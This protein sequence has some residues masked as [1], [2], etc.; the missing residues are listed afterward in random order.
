MFRW[1]GDSEVCYAFLSDVDADEPPSAEY[2]SF[3]MSRWFTRGWTLQELIAPGVVYFYGAG[4]KQIGSRETLLDIVVEITKI[5]AMYF[6]T[7]DLSKFPA[8]QKMSWAAGRDTTRVE[9]MAYCLLGIFGITMPLL[10]GEGERAFLRL[11]EEILRQSEDDSLFSHSYYDLLAPSHSFFGDSGRLSPCETWPYENDLSLTL[12]R[13]LS[14]SKGRITMTFPLVRVSETERL[15]ELCSVPYPEDLDGA[16]AVCHIALLNRGTSALILREESPGIFAKHVPIRGVV[17]ISPVLERTLEQRMSTRTISISRDTAAVPRRPWQWRARNRGAP[18]P[19]DPTAMAKAWNPHPPMR[20]NSPRE[21]QDLLTDR[22]PVRVE[23]QPEPEAYKDMVVIKGPCGATL[24]FRL[25]YVD[26][27]NFWSTWL[28]RGDEVYLIPED[29]NYPLGRPDLGSPCLIFSTERQASFM[30]SLAP[31]RA[32]VNADLFTNIPP[33]EGKILGRY[34]DRV[35]KQREADKGESP[36]SRATQQVD[37]GR[38]VMVGLQSRR[39][40]NGW[41]VYVSVTD[42]P[43]ESCPEGSPNPRTM[44]APQIVLHSPDS[45]EKRII[46]VPGIIK[47]SDRKG[48]TGETT[49]L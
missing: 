37:S 18:F 10:Y 23:P 12:D 32:S 5:S 40:S 17:R 47:E 35:E 31:T 3:S 6:L 36:C 9:D 19:Y 16:P 25:R 8:A 45:E 42:M 30:I 11:Q 15:D 33:W 2:S 28:E 49:K 39:R 43:V 13:N 22:D 4:W 20:P 34:R 48:G 27:A 1:Y 38:N 14:I 7:G 26:V 46:L 44:V 21:V 24:G 41:W 29:A